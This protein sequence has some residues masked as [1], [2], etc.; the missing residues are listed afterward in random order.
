MNF[1]AGLRLEL[2]IITNGFNSTDFVKI[3]KI[4]KNMKNASLINKNMLASASNPAIAKIK[5]LKAQILELKVELM[6]LKY[7]LKED[8]KLI[9]N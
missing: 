5:K 9:I 7:I 8:Q 3:E 6:K 2:A 1:I 4:A